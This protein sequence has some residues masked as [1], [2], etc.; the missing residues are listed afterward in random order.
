MSSSLS[1]S[2]YSYYE[3]TAAE[4]GMELSIK[5]V[6][7]LGQ[8]KKKKGGECSHIFVATCDDKVFV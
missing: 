5:Y 4:D 3:K 8:K 7:H 1:D 2:R 6:T